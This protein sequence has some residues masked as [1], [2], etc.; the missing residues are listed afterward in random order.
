MILIKQED[1]LHKAQIL[2]LLAGI[3]DN[4]ILSSSL[5]F[6]GGTCALMLGFLDRFSVDLD[7]D[8]IKEADKRKLDSE[9]RK[10]FKKLDLE[11]ISDKREALFYVVKYKAP[12]NQRNT[13]KVSAT[14]EV[15]TSNAYKVVML[16]EIN[17]LV[18]C[19][20][21]ETMFA[22][23]L[24]A[25]TDRYKKYKKIAGR[26]I[27]DIHHFFSKG[28][29][30]NPKIIEERTDMKA[31]KYIK[32][33]TDFIEKKVTERIIAEDLNTLLPYEIFKKI[34]KTLKPETSIFL[35]SLT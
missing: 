28:Y 5:H 10:L 23:K 7:F 3:V 20:T 9:F 6:K 30:F 25:V 4:P 14:D 11:V 24:V 34:R 8:L 19:Q 13:L 32:Y 31:G 35:K 27:Y 15:Y 22:N 1:I 29:K 2:R 26:D 33:L 12:K 16:S 21:I 18:S 17:R